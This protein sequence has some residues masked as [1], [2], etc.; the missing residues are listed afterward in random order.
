[1]LVVDD[2]ES[3][4]D[5]LVR[6]L[7]REGLTADQAA[8]GQEA[9]EKA[10]SISYDTILLDVMMPRLDGLST[11]AILKREKDLSDIPVIMLSAF[12]ETKAVLDCIAGGA[13]DYLQ[14]P[15]D[16]ALLRARLSS[17]LRRKQLQDREKE[18]QVQLEASNRELRRLNQLKSRFQAVAAHDL[19]SPMSA[20]LLQAD[21]LL[22]M[23]EQTLSPGDQKLVARRIRDSI[24]RML[25]TVQGLMDS[26]VYE[27]EAFP[28]RLRAA[29]FVGI[30][31]TVLETNRA[32]ADSK[33][34]H[35]QAFLPPGPVM[36]QVDEARIRE[37][38]DNLVNN[39]IKFSPLDRIVEVTLQPPSDDARTLTVA[40]RDQGP[41]LNDED[42][43]AVFGA[44]QRLS[45]VPTA[46]ET[47]IGIGLSIVKQMV[48][49]HGGRVWVE[50]EKGKGATFFLELP[51]QGA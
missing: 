46:G 12:N 15:I 21:K 47:S 8:D 35:L 14:K 41:G 25:A 11:L 43:A 27:S 5:A 50:S 17:C 13:D 4:R 45:A 36:L 38:L 48:E 10:R 9:L 2:L 30:V 1:V 16:R 39:A 29:D 31:R 51:V 7:E 33:R 32:Y 3:N 49:L 18:H 42:K 6:V 26:A 28:L 40:V 34:I 24:H 44:Y 22:N 37:A 23:G 19:K 20:V